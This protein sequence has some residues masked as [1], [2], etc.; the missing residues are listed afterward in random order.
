MPRTKKQKN[1]VVAEGERCFW[2]NNGPVLK[3]LGELKTALLAMGDEQF[4][5]HVGEQK[6]DFAKW[7]EEVL[8]HNKCAQALLKAKTR[9]GAAGVVARH[10]GL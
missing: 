7:V 1:L 6:N 5:H 10:L 2:V 3:D 9:K 8:C 4:T